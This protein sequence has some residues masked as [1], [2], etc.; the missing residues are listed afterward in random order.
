MVARH[1][2]LYNIDKKGL[3]FKE[4]KRRRLC[5]N[6]VGTRLSS[7]E[8]NPNSEFVSEDAALDYLASILVEIYLH[9]DYG[10]TKTSS[11]L[12]QGVN[13]RTSR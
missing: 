9:N 7:L 3:E 5:R 8:F 2:R 1:K 4:D 10:H 6:N 11:Y 12:L 13:E